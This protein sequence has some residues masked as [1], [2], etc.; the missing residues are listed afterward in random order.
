MAKTE[1]E[2]FAIIGLG[3]F[4]ISAGLALIEHGCR[5]M[6]I[7]SD[8]QLVQR[9][10]DELTYTVTLDAT[11]EQALRAAEIT[12]F[13]TVI[14]AIGTD[15]EAGVLA[16]ITLKS[17]GI[18]RVICKALSR[19]QA[20]VLRRV[21][22]DQV[23]LPEE[24]A[25]QRLALELSMPRL[26]DRMV[27]TPGYSVAEVQLP[28]RLEG[29]TLAESELRERFNAMVLVIHSKDG[30]K[31]APAYDTVL[32]SGDVLVILGPDDA[33]VQLSTGQ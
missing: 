21:G 29:K 31:I 13:K 16:T 26:I 24:E 15:F 25:G 8:A 22:A 30:T 5:V 2:E 32:H 7:D 6:G 9:Y 19:Q 33:I 18:P 10:A 14:V 1:E 20:E 11:D 27:M 12:S 17:M 28:A 4:G 23:I 3:R